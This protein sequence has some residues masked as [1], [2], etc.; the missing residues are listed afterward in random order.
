VPFLLLVRRELVKR[1]PE[2]LAPRQVYGLESEEDVKQD[3]A[4]RSGDRGRKRR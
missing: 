1:F 2:Q 4:V 3:L